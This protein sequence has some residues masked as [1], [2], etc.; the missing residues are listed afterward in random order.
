M[1]H[2]VV[3]LAFLSVACSGTASQPVALSTASPSQL[4]TPTQS[5]SSPSPSDLPLVRVGFSCRLPA[6]T[7]L[8]G[9]FIS[10]PDATF[11]ADPAGGFSQLAGGGLV[12]DARPRLQSSVFNTGVFFD[13]VER[14][15]VPVS[16]Y[17]VSPDGAFYAYATYDPASGDP[18]HV[19]VVDIASGTEK[20]LPAPAP[21]AP[22]QG[23]EVADFTSL[24]IYLAANQVNSL[25]SG[26][27][28]MDPASGTIKT[29]AQVVNV[30]RIRNGYAWTLQVDPRDPKPPQ[31]GKGTPGDSLVRVDLATGAKTEWVYRPGEQVWLQ[32]L[33]SRGGTLIVSFDPT[34]STI[35]IETRLVD[36]AG[37]AGVLIYSGQLGLGAS[38]GDRLWLVG[39]RAIYLYTADHGLQKVFEFSANAQISPIGPCL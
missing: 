37:A 18:G 39:D 12:T 38:D 31:P 5:P 29:L 4:V 7:S 20:V 10:F 22:F 27:W 2:W 35:Q 3:I 8:S 32:G 30:L 25:P 26:A 28:L 11:G 36:T 14:R 19:H 33:D 13:T 1:R 16:A 23:F 15:W 24:G 6:F 34:A 9:G 21:P 17:Q